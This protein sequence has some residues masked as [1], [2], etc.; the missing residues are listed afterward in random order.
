[1]GHHDGMLNGDTL[2]QLLAE[3][4]IEAFFQGVDRAEIVVH[5]WDV[6]DFSSV[7][8]IETTSGGAP[9]GV[10]I[11]VPKA[12]IDYAGIVCR[13]GRDLAMA[14][15]EYRSLC[16]LQEWWHGV[17]GVE[18]VEPLAFYEEHGA[19]V[20]RRVYATDLFLPLRRAD[21]AARFAFSRVGRWEENMRR[22]G[23]AVGGCQ[24]RAEPA[25][26]A[27]LGAKVVA[28]LRSIARELEGYGVA[29]ESRG[30]AAVLERWAGREEA[31]DTIWT[32]KGL[33][34][35]N[36]LIGE[37]DRI[38]LLDP[39]KMKREPAMAGLARYLATCEILYWGSLWL[40]LRLRPGRRFIAAT[41]DGYGGLSPAERQWLNLYLL[42]EFVHHWRMA[43]VSLRLK[44]W[45][46]PLKWVLGR[47]YID[48]FYRGAV[49]KQVESLQ[50]G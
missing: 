2:H 28:K 38:Y 10:F 31:L 42:K 39:G 15:E 44:R 36:V 30:L 22:I 24:R 5:P 25:R 27:A 43:H 33:D 13:G 18:F 12:E 34:L 47:F 9:S 20:T 50:H 14:R 26:E 48:R 23:T 4:V 6:L 17:E 46:G 37:E 45:P 29:V 21:L 41:L 1:M 16:A 7:F 8:S 32:L 35:R 19:I 3:R 40:F 49:A 11:K